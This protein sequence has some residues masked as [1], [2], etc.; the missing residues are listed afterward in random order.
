MKIKSPSLKYITMLELGASIFEYKINTC[1]ILMVFV[2][3]WFFNQTFK[4]VQRTKS[5]IALSL[6]GTQRS[7]MNIK[8]S[9]SFRNSNFKNKMKRRQ[10]LQKF[11]HEIIYVH[12]KICRT[13]NCSRKFIKNLLPE[14]LQKKP[15]KTKQPRFKSQFCRMIFWIIFF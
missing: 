5:S 12:E 10:I 8:L 3:C 14:K 15:C 7:P 13:Q 2:T 6:I 11:A 1:W 4:I 9:W